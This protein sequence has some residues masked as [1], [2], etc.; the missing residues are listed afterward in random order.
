MG[1]DSLPWCGL[2]LLCAAA[3][4]LLAIAEDG[5]SPVAAR[6][7]TLQ[8]DLRSAVPATVAQA[9]YAAGEEHVEGLVPD[10]VAILRDGPRPEDPDGWLV[11]GHVLDALIRLDAR[12]PMEV[13][14]RYEDDV[15]TCIVILAIRNG[16]AAYPLLRRTLGRSVAGQRI[17][18]V[19]VAAGH[20][21]TAAKDPHAAALFLG[22]IQPVLH[23]TVVDHDRVGLGGGAGGAMGGHGDGG[24]EV[25]EGFRDVWYE[26]QFRKA[27]RLWSG[28]LAR[29]PVV[30]VWFSR[31]VDHRKRF[32][33]GF[34]S[35]DGDVTDVGRGWAASLLGMGVEQLPLEKRYD[36][37]H[38]WTD[39]KAYLAFVDE[40]RRQVRK[41]ADALMER[42]AHAGL[43]APAERVGISISPQ[44]VVWDDRD[45]RTEPLPKV[46]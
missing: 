30:D 4:P 38:R 21:L 6:V 45:D 42:L 11:V 39:A 1:R 5:P 18:A 14:A 37:R 27:E 43:L 41:D 16:E 3:V 9:A 2:A 10:L 46:E 7:A 17:A 31:W 22:H 15:R 24:G 12:V 19:G 33:L 32:I 29:G 44:V 13:L 40:E 36:G 25:P 34:L 20:V 35:D 23:L 28:L 26:L 8:R